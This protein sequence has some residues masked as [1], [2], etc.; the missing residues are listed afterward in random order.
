MD[1]ISLIW[2]CFCVLVGI[3]AFLR[4]SAI[5][6]AMK[7]IHAETKVRQVLTKKELGQRTT[8]YIRLFGV[9]WILGGLLWISWLLYEW[10]H[11]S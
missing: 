11:P 8:L 3:L 4:S 2:S 9:V 1:K 5:A 10:K 6:K 7:T